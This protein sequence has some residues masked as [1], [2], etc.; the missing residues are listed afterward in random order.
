M[1]HGFRPMVVAE[2]CGDRTPAI[3]DA[4]IADLQAKY[5][6]IPTIS[7]AAARLATF[8]PIQRPAE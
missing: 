1:Q 3:H 7:D 6:D 5:A 2:A 8:Q 4:N